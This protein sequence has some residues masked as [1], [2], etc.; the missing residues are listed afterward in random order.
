[1]ARTVLVTGGTGALGRALVPE[2]VRRG[3]TVRVLSR[4]A[5]EDVGGARRRV[6][7]VLAGTGLAAAMSDVDTIVHAASNYRRAVRATEVTGTR[8]LL[9]AARDGGV[10]H[11][12]YVSI[13]GVDG[14]SAV[15][16]YR[17]KRD[18]EQIVEHSGT[19]WTV[20]RATQFHPLVD[21]LLA[22][23]IFPTT[24][25]LRLQPVDTGDVAL[26][27]AELVDGGPVGRAPD[28]GGPEVLTVRELAAIR[29]AVTGRRTRIVPL[30]AWGPLR[31]FDVGNQLCPEHADG[32][33]TWEQWLREHA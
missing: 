12:L 18:A 3:H 26:R 8:N 1:M 13:V 2:L 27:L 4:R 16:Y 28:F 10:E 20:Q 19:Q 30:P 11:V 7:D 22:Y 5:G 33:V 29:R 21:Q 32:T 25:N 6:G 31:G 9:D 23:G 24:P 15:P 17:A 14:N